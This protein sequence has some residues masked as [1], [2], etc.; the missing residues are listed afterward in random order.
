MLAFIRG[1]IV[2]TLP[3]ALVVEAGGVGYKVYVTEHELHQRKAAEAV[4]LYLS[5]VVREDAQD[6]YGFETKEELEFFERLLSVSGVGPKTALGAVS[7]ASLEGLKRAIAKGDAGLL[8]KVSGIGPKT[9]ERIVVELRDILKREQS[10]SSPQGMGDTEVID[11]LVALGYTPHDAREVVR[12]LSPEE[13]TLNE[14]LKAAL[15]MLAK[16]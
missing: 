5:H 11:A 2:Y 14:R 12:T 4:E 15:K 16:V 7:S 1:T 9:A 10:S 3:S 6:L 8:R 13:Q